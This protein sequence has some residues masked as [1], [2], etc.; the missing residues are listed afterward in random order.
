MLKLTFNKD[1]SLFIEKKIASSRGAPKENDAK[2]RFAIH[3]Q[4]IRQFHDNCKIAKG[5]SVSTLAPVYVVFSNLTR[6]LGC[7]GNFTNRLCHLK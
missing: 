7:I 2:F 3:P 6:L 4:G 1:D 5:Q